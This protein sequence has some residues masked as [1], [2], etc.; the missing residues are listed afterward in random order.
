MIM[1]LLQAITRARSCDA[2]G[3]TFLHR[4]AAPQ[5]LTWRQFATEADAC[6]A[7]LAAHGVSAGQRVAIVVDDN[8]R[9]SV[10]FIGCV[11]LGAIPVPIQPPNVTRKRE[12][13][14]EHVAAIVRSADARWLVRTGL[15]VP[16]DWCDIP[17]LTAETLCIH[18]HL[19]A[20]GG[21]ARPAVDRAPSDICYLQFTSGSTH[22]PK[23]V[24]VTFDNLAS[25]IAA[26]AQRAGAPPEP[27]GDV[28]VSWMPL[29]HDFGL[30]GGLLTPLHVLGR[31]VLIPTTMFAMRPRVWLETVSEYRATLTS[32][33]NYGLRIAAKRRPPA[34]SLDLSAL[35]SIAIGAEPIR[36]A[37]CEAFQ[38]AYAAAGLR[39]N[40]LSPGYGLAESTLVVSSCAPE[41]PLSVARPSGPNVADWPDE[42]VVSCGEVLDGHQVCIIDDAGRAL[43]E[44]MVGQI[45][46]SGPSVTRGYF[47]NPLAT[48][49]VFHGSSLLTGDLGFLRNSQLYVTGRAK[50]VIIVRGRNLQPQSIEWQVATV[51]GIRPDC[52]AAFG[53]LGPRGEELIVVAECQHPQ[54]TEQL[55]E[56]VQTAV[57]ARTGQ[58]VD[59][60]ILI[61]PWTLPKTSSGK[62]R[63]AETRKR[64]LEGAL[65]LV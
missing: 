46:V 31:G 45:V 53:V 4:A 63:R 12:H 27:S 29:Y 51:P 36:P 57:L 6:A 20:N 2:P 18:D 8:R 42:P 3:I 52:V 39:S 38:Q 61:E 44:G 24:E 14:Q 33:T 43:D 30:I 34:G 28:G 7:T 62:L 41:D 5:T 37:V 47:G 56:H 48:S 54:R 16:G 21:P 32:S 13:Y 55:R 15:A 50:D 65:N 23:G 26:I 40:A 17:D 25:N 35:R 19:I 11:L 64:Y 1:N 60:V 9:F 22:A 10:A 58:R 49:R 59:R